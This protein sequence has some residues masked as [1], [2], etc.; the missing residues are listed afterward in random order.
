[1]ILSK[2]PFSKIILLEDLLG[3]LQEYILASGWP[4]LEG[5]LNLLAVCAAEVHTTC[6]Q[7]DDVGPPENCHYILIAGFFWKGLPDHREELRVAHLVGV[8]GLLVLHC[9]VIRVGHNLAEHVLFEPRPD[10]CLELSF[11]K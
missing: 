6:G 7:P 9:P 2:R 8:D 3:G 1:M 5:N 4:L 10:D 11:H